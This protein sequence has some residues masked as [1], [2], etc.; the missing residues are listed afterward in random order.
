[1]KFKILTI[2]L[3]LSSLSFAQYFKDINPGLGYIPLVNDARARALGR[4]EILSSTGPDAMFY[5]PANLVSISNISFAFSGGSQFTAVRDD[6]LDNARDVF[7]TAGYSPNTRLSQIVMAFPI[8]RFGLKD[9]AIIAVG[10]NNF[11]DY[12]AD[13]EENYKTFEVIQDPAF[14]NDTTKHLTL[15]H[16]QI[17]TQNVSGGIG[18]ISAA[19]AIRILENL[20]L[21]ITFNQSIQGKLKVAN[22][23]KYLTNGLGQPFQWFYKYNFS[24]SFVVLSSTIKLRDNLTV[25]LM[26]RP[27]YHISPSKFH[28][29]S[30]DS[31]G[32]RVSYREY[33]LPKIK[34][35]TVFGISASYRFSKNLLVVAEYQNR[36][37][38]D[39]DFGYE[40]LPY[41]DIKN[42]HCFRMGL[43]AGSKF[44]IRFG[45]FNE[46][47]PGTNSDGDSSPNLLNGITTGFG[48][49]YKYFH[50]DIY[51]ESSFWRYR[52]AAS[53]YGASHHRREVY[54]SIGATF[55]VDFK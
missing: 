41:N 46:A 33:H 19:G 38:D 34:M 2:A 20:A 51:G 12:K 1:M 6:L 3:F 52:V 35:P 27:S 50:A 44:P 13:Y 40:N 9:K 18:T 29:Q 47:I 45:Y 14:P 10:Y 31:T 53:E 8:E 4:T 39:Y 49:V 5:N 21:G 30:E 26:L 16:E 17:N 55:T 43:E 54:M 42:G 23:V 24:T 36:P 32:Y 15:T 7:Y 11:V 25:G 28:W 37:Y 48:I 22:E